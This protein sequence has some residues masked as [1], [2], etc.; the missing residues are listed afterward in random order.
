MVAIDVLDLLAKELC[1]QLHDTSKPA[2]LYVSI[3]KSVNFNN[4][5]FVHSIY[6]IKKFKKFVLSETSAIFVNILKSIKR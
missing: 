2:S 1:R 5:S 4:K 6:G 3:T